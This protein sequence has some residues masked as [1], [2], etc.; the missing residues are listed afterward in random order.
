MR[1]IIDQIPKIFEVLNKTP[2]KRIIIYVALIFPIYVVHTYKDE[3]SLL[4]TNNEK[5]VVLKNISEVQ[6]K[7]FTLRN[8]YNAEAVIVYLYQ[9]SGKNKTYKERVVF[10]TN[11]Y[12]PMSSMKIINLFSRANIIADLNKIDYCLVTSNSNHNESTIIA[13]FELSMGVITSIRDNDNK[14]LIGEVV[15]LFKGQNQT[16]YETLIKEGQIFTHYIDST[17]N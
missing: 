1:F 10:S 7:C 2:L 13:S 16:E 11:E 15:W 8:K 5:N 3:F 12:K 14:Q 4:M 9:P 17:N 6:E